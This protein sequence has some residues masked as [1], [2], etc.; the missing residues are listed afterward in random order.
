MLQKWGKGGTAIVAATLLFFISL[1]LPWVEVSFF[2]SISENGWQQL[3]FLVLILYA[4]PLYA[5][6]A[7]KPMNPMLGLV[8]SIIGVALMFVFLFSN[9]DELFG[10][11]SSTGLYIGLVATIILVVGVFLKNKE[12]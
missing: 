8:S 6:L 7:E 3:G 12:A 4:Y 5:T 11:Y 9:N 1:F 10:N 2:G